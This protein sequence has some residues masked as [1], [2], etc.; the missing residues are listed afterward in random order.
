MLPSLA[1]NSWA[2][3]IIL[4]QPPEYQGLKASVTMP[5]PVHHLKKKKNQHI[6]GKND[7]SGMQV[8]KTGTD[9]PG[10]VSISGIPLLCVFCNI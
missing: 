4:P 8:T 1:L 2:Q 10:G 3:V 5:R 6:N 7:T 9:G